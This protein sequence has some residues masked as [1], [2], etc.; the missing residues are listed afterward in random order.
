[1]AT[2]EFSKLAVFKW[3]EWRAAPFP[4]RK[5]R[6]TVWLEMNYYWVDPRPL[7]PN[8]ERHR[9]SGV[10]VGL[11]WF[12]LF[13]NYYIFLLHWQANSLPL[14]PPEKPIVSFSRK[15]NSSEF[16]HK[17][18]LRKH[19][20]HVSLLEKH[21]KRQDKWRASP[22][23]PGVKDPPCSAWGMGSVLGQGAKAP[24]AL[25]PEK[26][27]HEKEATWEQIQ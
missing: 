26:P 22:G 5:K 2:A 20:T 7:P 24:H 12:F 27:N 4:G 14:V 8:S 23:G 1:M 13:S 17:Q 6:Q 10:H 15:E 16:S 21:L 19:S 18:E 11:R 25:Q 9:A 3:T